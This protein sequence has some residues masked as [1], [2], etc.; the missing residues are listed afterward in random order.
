MGH[1]G[2]NTLGGKP[3]PPRS[4]EGRIGSLRYPPTNHARVTTGG[5]RLANIRFILGCGRSMTAQETVRV[6]VK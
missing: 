1:G 5:C 6:V 3:M 2:S 4:A